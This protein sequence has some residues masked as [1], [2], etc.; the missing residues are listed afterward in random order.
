[1]N[2]LWKLG[3]YFGLGKAF[4]TVQQ[5][6]RLY[7]IGIYFSRWL[8]MLPVL[9]ASSGGRQ[10]AVVLKRHRTTRKF[11]KKLDCEEEKQSLL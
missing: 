1:M 6:L 11:P 2:F 10:R 7:S 5:S 3:L 9:A 8:E 4:H